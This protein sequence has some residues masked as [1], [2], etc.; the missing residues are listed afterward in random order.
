MPVFIRC[1]AYFTISLLIFFFVLGSKELLLEQRVPATYLAL[2]D[3]VSHIGSERRQAGMDPVLNLDQF[4]TAVNAEMLS[5]YQKSF[6]DM[7]ELNQAILFL[8]ENGL[9]NSICFQ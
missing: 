1:V 6:R 7:A 8:H 3:I 4:R 2:E 9:L 5:R